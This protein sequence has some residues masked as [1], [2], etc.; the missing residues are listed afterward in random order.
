MNGQTGPVKVMK[1]YWKVKIWL[2]TFLTSALDTF[3][4]SVSTLAHV[5]ANE[6]ASGTPE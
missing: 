5:T 3:G 1:V 4:C 6:E 2:H